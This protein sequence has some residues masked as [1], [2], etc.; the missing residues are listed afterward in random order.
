[1]PTLSHINLVWYFLIKYIIL[2]VVNNNE[3]LWLV[4]PT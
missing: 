1:M 4:K 2:T 3:E